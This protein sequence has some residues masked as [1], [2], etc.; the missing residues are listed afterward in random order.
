MF[1]YELDLAASEIP[2]FGVPMY[3]N[4]DSDSE[5]YVDATHKVWAGNICPL[6]GAEFMKSMARHF[7]DE[8]PELEKYKK[9]GN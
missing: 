9:E 3:D 6:C 2:P 1:Y 7:R 5:E 8:H 4:D